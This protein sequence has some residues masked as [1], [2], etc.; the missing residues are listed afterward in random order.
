MIF[1]I[2]FPK[3]R[4]ALYQ[5]VL[6]IK[7]TKSFRQDFKDIIKEYSQLRTPVVR[8]KIAFHF[9]T[10]TRH[11]RRVMDQLTAVFPNEYSLV[12]AVKL[13]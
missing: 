4:I 8:S 13:Y 1:S 10:V 7:Q 2:N 11:R 12:S 6:R 5:F 3:S 9:D